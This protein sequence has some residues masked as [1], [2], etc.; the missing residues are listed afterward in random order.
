MTPTEFRTIRYA[1]GYSAEG[2]ARALR[3]QSGR[4]IRKWEAGD[5]DIPGPAQV[6]MRLLERRIITV[7]D[8]EGL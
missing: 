8:I 7:E 1:F 3:V 2:L 5:R 6:V 4:T